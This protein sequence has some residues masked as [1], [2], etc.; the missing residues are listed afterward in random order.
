MVVAGNQKAYGSAFVT[1][2]VRKPL[3]VLATLPRVLGPGEEVKLP[4]TVF[5]MEE[6][7]KKVMVELETNQFFEI[8]GPDKQTVNFSKT[9]DQ[10]ISF[11]LK[12]KSKPGIG[13]I[14]VT[15][16][17]GSEMAQYDIELDIRNPNPPVNEFIDTILEAGQTWE[18]TFKLAGMPGTNKAVLEVSNMPPI[19]FGRRLK[20]LISYPHGCVEQT[21][22]AAFPQLYL[23]DV[24]DLNEKARKM[25]EENI[26]VAI[27]RINSFM[28]P[29][30]GLRYWPNSQSANDWSTSYAG[31]FM[32]EA[33]SKGYSLPVNFRKNWLKYQ[34]QASKNWRKTNEKYRQDDLI[35][36]YRLY[37]LALTNSPDL[38]SMNR[39]REQ[40]DLSIQAKWRLAAAYTISGQPEIA[41]SIINNTSMD[42]KAYSGFNY[43]YGSKERDWAMIL[44][45]LTLMNKRS[46]G[47]DLAKKIS[48]VL[49]GKNWL[50][51]Q[52]TAYCLLAMSKFAGAESISKELKFEYVLESGGKTTNVSTQLQYAQFEFDVKERP[53][54]YIKV[55]NK[56]TGIIFARIAM[57]G[58]PEIGDQ[59]AIQ[60]NLVINV[61]YTDM[62]GNIFDVSR[63]LQGT[64]FIARVTVSNPTGVEHYREMVL[65]Q[66]FPSGWEIHNIRMDDV[67]SVHKSSIPNYQ[68]I[69][70]DRVYTYFHLPGNDQ[71]IFIFQLN[72]A[73]LGKFYLPSVY[74]EAMYDER[75]NA[76]KPGRWVEV[77]Q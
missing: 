58:I 20:Y 61:D 25:T 45:T 21:T 13:K 19:D 53:E 59:T 4:V 34:K 39:L 11:D 54:A 47:I 7:L 33:E 30:G 77:I 22:S 32:L 65:T 24:M 44:E 38:A 1:T 37:T 17:S 5:L 62:S 51:T 72:A 2:P 48:N 63:I 52:T 66:I 23:A 60:K 71:K 49:G 73:Y 29:G 28:L 50:S 68:D 9:G 26:K 10:V 35:Q 41:Q 76:R 69:R 55:I 74:C 42:I 43:S 57:E 64:D 75:I 70:D 16:K 8:T 56:S 67:S 18:R 31:H 6:N 3:M 40:T 46:E 12:V 27:I 14:Q 15:A 36:A